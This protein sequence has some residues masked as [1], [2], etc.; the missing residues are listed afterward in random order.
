[1]VGVSATKRG[2]YFLH[3]FVIDYR[4]GGTHYSAPLYQGMQL[5]VARACPDR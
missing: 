3:G 4:I 2:L 5:C 1:M